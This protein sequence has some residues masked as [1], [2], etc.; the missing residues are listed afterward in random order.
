MSLFYTGPG[1]FRYL[2]KEYAFGGKLPDDLPKD[3]VVSLQKKNRVSDAS[4][5]PALTKSPVTAPTVNPEELAAANREIAALREKLSSETAEANATIASL[6]S[7]LV[8][9]NATI[10][11]LTDQITSGAADAGSAGPKGKNK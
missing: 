6:Q 9:A 7:R 5:A 4:P 1:V 2:N 8:E 10:A 11:S 3:V